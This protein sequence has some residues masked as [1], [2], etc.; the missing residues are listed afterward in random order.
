MF[1][2][3]SLIQGNP[4]RYEQ[5]NLQ[6]PDRLERDR[7]EHQRARGMA[8]LSVWHPRPTSRRKTVHT[9]RSILPNPS[10]PLGLR[11]SQQP[12]RE[13]GSS[14]YGMSSWYAQATSWL[15]LGRP[16]RTRVNRRA[17]FATTGN[18]KEAVAGTVGA[19]EFAHPL[20]AI[21]IM[22]CTNMPSNI[23]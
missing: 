10:P 5:S 21:G 17:S 9:E 1:W 14:L 8:L 22:G 11:P 18:A 7:P 20:S 12:L 13:L 6:I 16:R 3:V 4:T 15:D 23:I 19:L 2:P